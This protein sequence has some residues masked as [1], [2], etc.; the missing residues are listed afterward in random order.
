M[1]NSTNYLI[2][3]DCRAILITVVTQ[4]KPNNY[5]VSLLTCLM[6]YSTSVIEQVDIDFKG[7]CYW[8]ILE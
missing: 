8:T 3:A 7:D 1:T 5:C 4:Q 6:V 2:V